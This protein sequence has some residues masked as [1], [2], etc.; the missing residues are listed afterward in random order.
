MAFSFKGATSG[1]LQ[2]NL[3]R[4]LTSFL[5]LYD[6]QEFSFRQASERFSRVAAGDDEGCEDV[7]AAALFGLC[8]GA[9]GAVCGGVT[10]GL[11]G[12]FGAV[13]A[14][15]FTRFNRDINA[16]GATVG[17]FGSVLGGVVGGAFSGSIGSA[18]DVAA[19]VAGYHVHFT[20]SRALWCGVGF[21]TGSAIGSAYG[22][23]VGELG[24][25]V[26]GACGALHAT[27][28]TVY[29]VGSFID[30]S[31]KGNNSTD[32]GRQLERANRTQGTREDFRKGIEPL[33]RELKTIQQISNKM[34]SSD[35]VK[36]VAGQTAKTL[37]AVDEMEK[38]MSDSRPQFCCEE[39]AKCCRK[40]TEE[41]QKTRA[42]VQNLLV[43]LQQLQNK[44]LK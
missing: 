35:A 18:V 5:Q 34:A 17:F 38:N 7:F 27:T 1:V 11:W 10:G 21:A 25:A 23:S 12:A 22:G 24:G 31:S 40:I 3:I 42:E 8:G 44:N 26:G 14:A 15:T 37:A 20:L 43:S 16:V 41:L 2:E 28:I 39:A 9:V 19:K 33:V 13:G 32:E 29:L 6:Q 30:W 4:S 36:S